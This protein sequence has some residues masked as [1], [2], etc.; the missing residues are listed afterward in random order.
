MPRDKVLIVDDEDLIRWSLRQKITNWGYQVSE[1]PTGQAAI[2]LVEKEEPDLVLLDIRLP[3]LNGLDVLRSIKEK[4]PAVVVIMMTAY[5]VLEE[6]VTALR[7]GAYDFV[8]KPLNFDE[9]SV[10]VGNALEA[11][12]LRQEVHHFRE[13]DKKLFDFRNIVGHSKALADAIEMVKK[14]ATSPATTILLQGESGT[15]KELFA[16]AI[17]YHS[18]RGERPFLAINCAALPENLVESELFGYEKGAFTDARQQKKGMMEL[19]DGGTM[20]LDEIGEMPLGL[21]AKL[22]RVLEEQTFKRVGGIQDISVDVRVIASSNRDLKAMIAEGKFRQDLFYRLNVI[23]INLP[24]LRERGADVKLLAR[25][26][27]QHY[28]RKFGKE[29]QGLTPEAESALMEYHW[30]GNVRELKNL[31]ERAMIL[32]EGPMIDA[33]ALPIEPSA[34]VSAPSTTPLPDLSL[35]DQGTS[36]ERVEEELVR[37][38]LARARGNQTRAAKLLDISRD[39]LRYKMKKFQLEERV[40]D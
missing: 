1:A 30:P 29:I 15:G 39:A 8:A 13:R 4:R 25:H 12:K 16:K 33:S 24:P 35:P 28:N 3:D 10:T 7:L 37:Q 11:V 5:G 27:I 23:A 9:L 22:L 21:Q 18:V 19:A 36:L 31:I 14:V 17:H 20:L 2:D 6:A 32:E 40:N 34:R 26:Y 38:A